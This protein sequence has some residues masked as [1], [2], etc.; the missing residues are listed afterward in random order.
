VV[1]AFA[2]SF[3]G[4]WEI[5]IP[6]FAQMDVSS[7][8]QHQEGPSGAFFKGVFTTLLA[9]PCSGPFLGPVFALTLSQPPL[10]TY[11]LFGSVGLGMASP[12]LLIGAFPALVKWLPKPGHWMETVK[13]LMGFVLLGTIVYL[14]TTL[15]HDYFIPTLALLMAVWLGCWIVGRVPVYE[16]TARQIRQWSLA[17]VVASAIGWLS[18][19]FLG[20]ERHLFPWQPYTPETVAKLQSDGKTVMVDFTANWCLTCRWNFR[21]AINTRRVKEVVERNGI[22][23]VLADWTDMN[24]TIKQK[25]I[26][27]NSNS[28]PLLAIYPA[29]R[30]SEV[31][32]L[33]DAITQNQ[34]LAALEKAG[35]SH[36]AAADRHQVTSLKSLAEPAAQ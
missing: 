21:N 36:S 17:V 2:L 12:Y 24:D 14:F 18:F 26:E 32:V 23:P 15:H 9:T 1:F 33:R 27:L 10:M 7:K 19:T 22:A 13:Q 34:L 11:V 16:S 31:I 25:L 30:P 8:L 5:P 29:E 6:G 20:P 28:I 3:L 4:V 35:P